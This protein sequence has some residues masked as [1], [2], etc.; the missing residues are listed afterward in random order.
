MNNLYKKL[1]L[2]QKE[3]KVI[4]KDQENPYFK[5][6]YFDINTV[7]EELKPLFNKHDLLVLQPLTNID[8]MSCITTI[9]IDESGEKMEFTTPLISNTDPQKFGAII[10]YTRR[11]ALT[12]LFLIQGELDDDA[13]SVSLPKAT[14]K[15]D[16]PF[17]DTDNVNDIKPTKICVKCKNEHTG[18]YAKCLDCWKADKSSK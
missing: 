18:P 13:N 6:K 17:K 1:L 11:Y 3:I 2:L 12:S 15:T 8:G 4:I 10:T 7:I 14:K 5:S 9:L 16:E